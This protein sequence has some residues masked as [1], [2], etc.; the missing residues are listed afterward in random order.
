MGELI[1]LMA[2][3]RFQEQAKRVADNMRANGV[4]A[5]FLEPAFYAKKEDSSKTLQTLL[6][7]LNPVAATRTRT[8]S[9]QMSALDELI[10]LAESTP[11]PVQYW[12]PL[13]LS[14]RISGALVMTRQ[15]VSCGMQ[16]SSMAALQWQVSWAIALRER[17]PLAFPIVNVSA[18]LLFIRGPLCTRCVGCDA[19]SCPASNYCRRWLL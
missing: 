3:P 13:K 9:T 18:R 4:F 2:N 7:A 6:L 10:E 17:Y 16:R 12:D 15:L 11:G 5:V 14:S 1:K 8:G 19:I